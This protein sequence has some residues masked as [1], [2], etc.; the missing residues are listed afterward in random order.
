MKKSRFELIVSSYD[1]NKNL[2]DEIK[3]NSSSPDTIQKIFI[4]STQ[5]TRP[6]LCDGKMKSI[7]KIDIKYIKNS[8]NQYQNAACEQ[9][10]TR[11]KVKFCQTPFSD[12][13]L[14]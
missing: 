1:K 7:E 4:D 6:R 9:K 8:K 2:H 10:T 14:T 11:E 3:H 12:T 5:K 13:T